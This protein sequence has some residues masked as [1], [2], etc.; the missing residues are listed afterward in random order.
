[1]DRPNDGATPEFLGSNGDNQESSSKLQSAWEF[2]KLSRANLCSANRAIEELGA[3]L[4]KLELHQERATEITGD[5]GRTEG[6]SQPVARSV[7]DSGNARYSGDRESLGRG[8]FLSGD[9]ARETPEIEPKRGEGKANQRL[10]EANHRA[11][12]DSS[13]RKESSTKNAPAHSQPIKPPAKNFDLE[14]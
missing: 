9:G 6:L 14:L 5:F 7:S 8:D 1:M 11:T 4:D 2:V 3:T 13:E 12:E 10:G